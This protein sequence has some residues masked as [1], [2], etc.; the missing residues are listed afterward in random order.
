M[1]GRTLCTRQGGQIL[2][3]KRESPG[4]TKRASHRGGVFPRRPLCAHA[5]GTDKDTYVRAKA[6]SALGGG[7]LLGAPAGGELV[8]ARL[9]N[10]RSFAAGQRGRA[11][12]DRCTGK[13]LRHLGERRGEEGGG[14]RVGL[15]PVKI[16]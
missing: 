1:P 9:S 2:T 10:L 11:G 16:L 7:G 5:A 14:V 4:N 12:G 13:G 6:S 8:Q 15:A 3:A